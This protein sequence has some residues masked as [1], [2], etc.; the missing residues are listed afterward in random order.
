[1]ALA[2]LSLSDNGEQTDFRFRSDIYCY[3][4]AGSDNVRLKIDLDGSFVG[5]LQLVLGQ[6]ELEELAQDIARVGGANGQN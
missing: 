2:Y 3:R 6:K 4:E 5:S 1:M